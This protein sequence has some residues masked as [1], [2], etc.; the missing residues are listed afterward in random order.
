MAALVTWVPP[1]GR[2]PSCGEHQRQFLV[3]VFD[4]RSL[5]REQKTVGLNPSC[6]VLL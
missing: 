4:R 6:K 3:Y 2:G 5:T 1:L